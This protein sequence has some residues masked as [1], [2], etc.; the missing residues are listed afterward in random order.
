[1][2]LLFGLLAPEKELNRTKL[3][4]N[5]T[6]SFEFL[7]LPRKL[8]PRVFLYR[9]LHA[10]VPV[11]VPAPPVSFYRYRYRYVRPTR[12][13]VCPVCVCPGSRPPPVSFILSLLPGV[14][15]RRVTTRS[16]V[17]ERGL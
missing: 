13:P 4:V 9:Y 12:C 2:V 3:T 5:L 1:V 17:P 10:P 15:Q 16:R 7:R 8:L 11:C 6:L 14:R